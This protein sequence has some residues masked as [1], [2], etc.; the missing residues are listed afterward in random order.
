M[1]SAHTAQPRELADAELASVHGGG[2]LDWFEEKVLKPV[3]GFFRGNKPPP[4]FPFDPRN[5][6]GSD[7]QNPGAPGRP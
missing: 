2:L 4:N 5:P 7:P 3:M 1:D 6:F